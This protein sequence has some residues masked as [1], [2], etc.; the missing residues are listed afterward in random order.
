MTFSL[1]QD[2]CGRIGPLEWKALQPRKWAN[3]DIIIWCCKSV[4]HVSGTYK[5]MSLSPSSYIKEQVSPL[6]SKTFHI[7]STVFL[8]KWKESSLPSAIFPP[9]L[10]N[11]HRNPDRVVSWKGPDIFTLDFLFFPMFCGYVMAIWWSSHC[12]Y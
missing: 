12:H 11:I 8:N 5:D 2:S 1:L 10:T 3:D 9:I 6:C 4:F 7:M